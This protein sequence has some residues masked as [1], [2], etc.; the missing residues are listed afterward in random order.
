MFGIL[1]TH[2]YSLSK[3]QVYST[4]WLIIVTM[5]Y[6]RSPEH[7][8]SS[9]NCK[10]VSCDKPLPIDPTLQPMITMDPLSGCRILTFMIAHTGE[11]MRFFPCSDLYHLAPGLKAHVSHGRIPPILWLIPHCVWISHLPSPCIC[12][13]PLSWGLGLGYCE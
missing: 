4:V 12:G 1:R 8:H 7:L 13:R 5:L 3:F 2:I 9:D 10:C 11:I 6:L